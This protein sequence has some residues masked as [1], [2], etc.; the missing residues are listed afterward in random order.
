[1]NPKNLY[2]TMA[3]KRRSGSVS[4]LDQC[5]NGSEWDANG[6]NVI[7]QP[8]REGHISPL[9]WRFREPLSQDKLPYLQM[10][11]VSVGRVIKK[12]DL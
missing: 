5:P 11:M 8:R 12:A 9:N 6:W 1:M 3:W 4:A 7:G 10:F 2:E